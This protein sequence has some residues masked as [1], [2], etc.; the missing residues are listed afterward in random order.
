MKIKTLLL[1]GGLYVLGACDESI[2]N[3]NK[4]VP[5]DYHQILY[6]N[7]SGKQELT[8]YDTDT[9]N[10]YT[11]SVIKAGSDPNQI[12]SVNINV[13]TP[14]ELYRKYSEPEGV[15]YKIISENSY[16]IE[17]NQ[18]DFSA[19]DR[20]KIVT[21]Y[22]KP[23]AVKAAMETDLEAVWVLPLQATSKTDSI[24][25]E[26]DELFLK[27]MDVITPALG[28]MNSSVNLKE[29]TYGSV[30]T[31]SEKI[32]IGLDTENKWDIEAQIGV[33]M[34]YVATYNTKNETVFQA[35]P[36]GLY[37]MPES[38]T[39]S[40]GIT[41]SDLTVTINASQLEPGDYMLPICIT[42]ISLF[43]ISP[44]NAVYP[45]AIRVLGHQLNR[46]GWT[47]EANTQELSGEGSGNGIAGCVLDGNFSTYWHSQWQGG[48]HVL[49]HEL[50]VDTKEEYTFT[51]FA[52]MQRQNE[53]YTD[54]GDGE[55]YVSSDK[56]AW[57]KVGTFAMQKILST[58]M[59][60]ITPTKGRYFMIRITRSNRDL[61]CSLSEVYA[62]G[63]K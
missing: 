17:T 43:E 38:I 58:Q 16:S 21:I 49:P 60:A 19:I 40:N 59:F 25:A 24:N 5:N 18:L 50:I 37:S 1:I 44:I 8:L 23:Q 57:V 10:K 9:D 7:N 31:I 61:N 41:S 33:D 11:L 20:Y 6:V 52:M 39:F 47:A 63:L 55:F 4:M 2:Y 45:L 13:L 29:F 15:N 34:N 28:F 62:Y 3:L 46:A 14:E 36:Q 30:S 35:L 56:V 48:N 54:T 22:L 26:K 12:A 51:Q 53:S 27:I 32:N 42:D